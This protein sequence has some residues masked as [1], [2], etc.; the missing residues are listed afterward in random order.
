MLRVKRTTGT[1]WRGALVGPLRGALPAIAALLVT[2]LAGVAILIPSSRSV[3]IVDIRSLP[4]GRQV[5]AGTIYSYYPNAELE[6][7]VTAIPGEAGTATVLA[8]RLR[9]AEGWTGFGIVTSAAPPLTA[10][11]KIRWRVSGAADHVQVDVQERAQGAGNREGEIFSAIVPVAGEQWTTTPLPLR[12]LPANQYYQPDPSSANGVLDADRLG[13]LAFTFPPGSDLTVEIADLTCEWP[14]AKWQA[15]GVLSLCLLLTLLLQIAL[16]TARR[17]EA[18]RTLKASE[19]NYL[20]IFNAVKEGIWVLDPAGG[21]T[22]DANRSACELLGLSREAMIGE[23]FASLAYRFG[24]GTGDVPLPQRLAELTQEWECRIENRD[25]RFWWAELRATATTIGDERRLLLAARDVSERKEAEQERMRLEHRLVQSQK[26]E[27]LGQLA[28]GVAHDFNN[29][30]TGITLAAEVALL[31]RQPGADPGASI[32]Q[33]RDLAVRATSLTQQMLMFSRRQPLRPTPVRLNALV[34]HALSMLRRLIGEDINVTFQ[35]GAV[36]DLIRADRGQIEQVLVNLAVN[37]RDAM[38]SGGDLTIATR[39]LPAGERPPGSLPD[40]EFVVLEVADSGHGMDDATRDRIFEPFFTTKEKG[41]GTGLG[42]ATVYGIVARHEATISVDSSP[43]AG[44]TF[45][46]CFPALTGDEEPAAVQEP[47]AAPAP[48]GSELILVVE[49][50]DDVRTLLDVTLRELGYRTV[51]A[52]CPARAE[53]IYR[54][55]RREVA[56][57]LTDVV[58]PG[59]SGPQFYRRLA[60]EDPELKVVFMS[61]YADARSGCEE[62]LRDGLPFIQKPFDPAALA[63][64]IRRTLDEPRRE[65]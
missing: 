1:R 40:A 29:I 53:P 28:G 17:I 25:G 37:A 7:R 10:T 46:V 39:D 64:L 62:V 47:P 11:L 26:M 60:R 18:E 38:P 12:S 58:M 33:I 3:A 57:L 24:D 16:L 52:E 35:A 4:P 36:R 41:K 5:D 49:D 44:S 50:N 13:R 22:L 45:R 55:R 21:R 43:G 48:R 34:E 51:S 23:P 20:A 31:K 2:A 56:L 42:L 9:P 27:A 19:A 14:G 30:L 8:C 61:G 32:R 15:F 54:A 65:S 59:E 6:A 63:H